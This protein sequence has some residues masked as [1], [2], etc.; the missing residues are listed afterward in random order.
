MGS[1]RVRHDLV[2]KQQQIFSF[3]LKV[4]LLLPSC[5][6]LN[7]PT[8][9]HWIGKEKLEN[10]QPLLKVTTLK[11]WVSHSHPL[12]SVFGSKGWARSTLFLPAW[13]DFCSNFTAE[14]KHEL[15]N[16]WRVVSA[17]SCDYNIGIEKLD[18]F[19]IIRILAICPRGEKSCLSNLQSA[20]PNYLQNSFIS[21]SHWINHWS[22]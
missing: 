11:Y 6:W 16:G 13:Q 5:E 10:V 19:I 21:V 14:G 15:F 7:C 1:Q 20:H 17:T 3:L 8:S 18:T 4:A 2:T 9:S 12:M 22:L